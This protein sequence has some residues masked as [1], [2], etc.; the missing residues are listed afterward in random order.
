[1]AWSRVGDGDNDNF[2]MAALDHRR[3]GFGGLCE[4]WHRVDRGCSRRGC[5]GGSWWLFLPW[6]LW[7]KLVAVLA[8]AA[9]EEVRGRGSRDTRLDAATAA[10]CRRAALVAEC[11]R[12]GPGRG[13]MKEG[14]V[15]THWCVQE[16]GAA[17]STP[18]AARDAAL[19]AE[20]PPRLRRGR[21]TRLGAATKGGCRRTAWSRPNA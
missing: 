16:K 10:G 3:P 13:V 11:R 20:K 8:V 2:V 1:M 19:G 7:R 9:A 12:G 14:G 4:L 18:V 6:L 17:L 21:D 5:G 15:G